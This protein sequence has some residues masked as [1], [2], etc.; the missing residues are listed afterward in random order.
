MREPDPVP[1][2]ASGGY[3]IEVRG[4]LDLDAV[5]PAWCALAKRALVANPYCEHAVLAA[6]ARHLPQGRFLHVLMVRRGETLVGVAP[7]VAPRIGAPLRRLAPWRVPLLP[8]ATPLLDRGEAGP[9]LDALIA[10]ARERGA[11]FILAGRPVGLRPRRPGARPG[12]AIRGRASS[13]RRLPTLRLRAASA[14]RRRAR[15][16]RSATPS[17][18]FL[19]LEAD[20]AVARRA[21]ALVQDPGQANLVRTATRQA[22]REKACRVLIARRDDSPVAAAVLMRGALWLAAER[23]DAPGA[24]AALLAR[25]R[26]EPETGACGLD[27]RGRIVPPRR[28]GRIPACS[29]AARRLFAPLA[30]A[31]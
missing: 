23:P 17:M 16:P 22:A 15:P 11:A 21:L 27:H 14:S 24:R 19:T 9:V 28:S 13:R 30:R 29:P 3:E 5:A 4:A 26:Y 7:V 1:R 10:F 12:P 8:A 6:A 2:F 25:A 18:V 20:C 31:S